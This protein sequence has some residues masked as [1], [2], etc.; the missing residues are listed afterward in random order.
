MDVLNHECPGCS[1][2]IVFNPEKQSWDCNY[3]G[4]SYTVEDFKKYEDEMKMKEFNF[5][6]KNF[7][8]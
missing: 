4:M 3:C 5:T 8:Q 6:R 7:W 2:N 1:A